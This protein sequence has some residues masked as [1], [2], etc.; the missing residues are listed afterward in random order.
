MAVARTSNTR[1]TTRTDRSTGTTGSRSVTGRRNAQLHRTVQSINI[2]RFRAQG[3]TT[4]CNQAVHAI[5][6]KLG[7][8]GFGGLVA[9]QMV[10]KMQSPGSG[11]RQVSAQE[12]IRMAQSGKLVVAGWYNNTPRAGRPDGRA[13]GHVA[14]VTG[15]FSPGVPGI[16]QAG[17]NTFEWG[18]VRQ[19]FG[20]KNV[21]YF[22]RG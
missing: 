10:R 1:S 13:P 22:V 3:R 14:V 16:A 5:A 19:G 12:A 21:S 6:S 20:S 18:S 11:F 7:Y 2:Q 9:N 17:R 8:R 15:E 4:F